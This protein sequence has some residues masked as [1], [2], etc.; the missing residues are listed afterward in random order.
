MTKVN[1]SQF[2]MWRTIFALAHADNVVTNEEIRFMVEALEDIPFTEVQRQTLT[3]DIAE[4]RDI[5]AMFGQVSDPKDQAAFFELA[6][7]MVWI[8]GDYGKEERDIMLKLKEL[9][10][11]AANL[12]DLV[13]SISLE[14]EG[15]SRGDGNLKD[16]MFSFRDDFLKKIT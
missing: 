3:T 15:E 11:R 10:V 12:D 2:A 4:P 5:E 8:D 6:R 13:G 9:H 16:T 14:F 1:D 7:K